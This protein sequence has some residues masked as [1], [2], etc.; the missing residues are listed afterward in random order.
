MLVEPADPAA[1]PP[2]GALAGADGAA[3]LAARARRAPEV[4]YSAEAGCIGDLRA[5][6]HPPGSVP[7]RARF[8][9][10]NSGGIAGPARALARFLRADDWR[11]NLANDQRGAYVL[12]AAARANASLPLAVTDH[13]AEMFL[14]MLDVDFESDVAWDA[15]AG[16]WRLKTAPGSAPVA[17]HWPSYFKRL[18]A[19]ARALAG[20]AGSRTRGALRTVMVAAWALGAAA[21]AVAFAAGLAAGAAAARAA[22]PPAG[23]AAAA[24]AAAGAACCAPAR[25]AAAAACARARAA[26][27]GYA[28]VARAPAGAAAHAP[29]AAD[30][31]KPAAAAAA[32]ARSPARGG[33]GAGTTPAGGGARRA[34]ERAAVR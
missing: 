15:R 12:V 26:A 13:G 19:G 16:A 9:C 21:A 34:A 17:W 2:G 25:A 20:D 5:A 4:V 8:P 27:A 10:L 1:P 31:R 32:A 28:P 30:V 7:P 23:A 3:L 33:R 24:A 14:T 11:N 6:A 22:R 18:S 29:D